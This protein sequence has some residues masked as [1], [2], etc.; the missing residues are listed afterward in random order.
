MEETIYLLL[1]HSLLW[2]HLGG[3]SGYHGHICD[4]FAL[5]ACVLRALRD[6]FLR[7]CREKA[8]R[9]HSELVVKECGINGSSVWSQI[10]LLHQVLIVNWYLTLL[11]HTSVHTQVLMFQLHPRLVDIAQILAKDTPYLPLLLITPEH[12]IQ[13][14]DLTR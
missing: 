10:S 6:E 12:R 2:R 14:C 3:S 8:L 13:V 4:G 5:T 1:S 7:V 9:I 11:H